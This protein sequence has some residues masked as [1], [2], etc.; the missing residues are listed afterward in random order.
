M[1]QW[2]CFGC[3]YSEIDTSFNQPL[4]QKPITVPT[5]IERLEYQRGALPPFHG[6]TSVKHQLIYSPWKKTTRFPLLDKSQC[7]FFIHHSVTASKY[8]FCIRLKQGKKHPANHKAIPWHVNLLFLAESL[9]KKM[10]A[11]KRPKWRS[12]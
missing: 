12:V 9:Q 1:A 10:F 11:S 3:Q 8:T 7:S 4:I 2:F 6:I 5:E